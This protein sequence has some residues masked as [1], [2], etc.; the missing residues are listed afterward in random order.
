MNIS[1]EED[2]RRG[3]GGHSFHCSRE[4]KHHVSIDGFERVLADQKCLVEAAV[5]KAERLRAAG[6]D[7]TNVILAKAKRD[8]RGNPWHAFVYSADARAT[9]LRLVGS[10]EHGKA[11]ALKEAVESSKEVARATQALEHLKT[12]KLPPGKRVRLGA[13]DALPPLPPPSSPPPPATCDFT[14]KTEEALE[15]AVLDAIKKHAGP[16]PNAYGVSAVLRTFE[17]K[18]TKGALH[19]VGLGKILQCHSE[20]KAAAPPLVR[21]VQGVD[22][23]QFGRGKPEFVDNSLLQVASQFN[24]LESASSA[25]MALQHY[26]HDRTQGPQASLGCPG[27]LAQRNAIFKRKGDLDIQPFFAGLKGAYKG[28][29]FTP[30]DIGDADLQRA[31]NYVS[32]NWKHLKVLV[33]SGRTLFGTKTTQVFMA[34]PSFQGE[35]TPSIETALGD[36]CNVTVSRQ[37]EAM[38]ALAAMQ[39]E[40]TGRRANLHVTMVGQGAFNNPPEVLKTSFSRLLQA[41]RGYDVALYVHAWTPDDAR[42]AAAAL[43][44]ALSPSQLARVPT[45]PAAAFYRE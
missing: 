38:G 4:D 2:S 20:R 15:S 35:G 37:Y 22:A 27:M 8:S 6:I 18:S 44:G 24:F 32:K 16:Q 17:D 36:I 9:E 43:S 42:K 1:I 39:S 23:F 21:I 12:V 41:V 30:N 19:P 10:A 29:Y 25:H 31:S 5:Q 45:L 34:A 33:Q 11:R 26:A 3:L 14:A 40:A 7:A 13:R 28:G